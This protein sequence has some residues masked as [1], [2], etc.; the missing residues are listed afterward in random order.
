MTR[1]RRWLAAPA[2]AL[3]FALVGA[4]TYP[5]VDAVAAFAPSHVVWEGKGP[6]GSK[7]KA[8]YE[9]SESDGVTHCTYMNE[10]D[11]PGGALGK[12]AGPAVKKVTGKELDSSLENLRKIVE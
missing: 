1:S 2:L 9:F 12:M 3:S 6:L 5:W 10:Y 7:A 8:T 4:A 11:L